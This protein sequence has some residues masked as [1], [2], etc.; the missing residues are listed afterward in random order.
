VFDGAAAS[1]RR[2]ALELGLFGGAVPEPDTLAFTT[3]RSTGGAFWSY[4]RALGAG[5]GFRQDGRI[6]VVDSPETGTR[7]EATLGGRAWLRSTALSAE[8]QLGAGGTLESSSPLDAARV[9]VSARPGAGVSLGAG[10]RHTGVDWPQAEPSL[11]PG[12]GEAADGFVSWD[13]W[14]LRVGVTA[15]LSRDAASDLDR[16]WFGPEIAVPRLLGSRLGIVAGYLE[17]LGWLEGRSAYA[18]LHLRA[19]EAVAITAGGS[20]VHESTFGADQDELGVSLGLAASLGPHLG[21]RVYALSRTAFSGEE[22]GG[23]GAHGVT[24]NGALSAAF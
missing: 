14:I 17:E 6:A 16:S 22:E 21:L 10:F 1:L 4:R 19:S 2:G 7:F 9:D 20:W 18:R 15:G 5:G 12:R 8:V 11:F 24:V 3:D 23:G 13:V